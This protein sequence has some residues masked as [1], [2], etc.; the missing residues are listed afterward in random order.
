MNFINKCIE[1]LEK[2]KLNIKKSKNRIY[3]EK[4]KET[5]LERLAFLKQGV[6]DFAKESEN[7]INNT[8]KV[9]FDILY[10]ELTQIIENINTKTHI[11][12]DWQ[13]EDSPKMASFDI[14]MVG[15]N[16]QVFK[17]SY[18]YLEDFITQSE[19][20]H[21]LL[22]QEDREIFV[23]YIYNFKLTV[24]VRSILGRSN[25]PVTFDDFKK[26]LES[27]FPNPKTLQQVLT[28]LGTTRQDNSSISDFRVKIDEL[29]TI[30]RLRIYQAPPKKLRMQ[31]IK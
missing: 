10:E 31:F 7:K 29:R 4:Y 23:K 24:Q 26:A 19:L 2:L 28:E 17:G 15:K 6:E 13:E 9:E 16:L 30:L 18:E 22:K 11:K 14:G 1:E 3:E 20:L 8:L 21:D 5:K 27:A 12:L 25:R